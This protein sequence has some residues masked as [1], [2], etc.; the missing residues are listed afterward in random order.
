METAIEEAKSAIAKA[1]QE[2]ALYYNRRRTPAPV[3]RK[4]DRVF[5]DASDISTDRPSEKLGNLRY[6][7]LEVEEKVRPASYRLKLP[8]E[9]HCLHPVFPVVK[10]TP[11]PE[12]P[13][14]G[15]QQPTPPPPIIVDNVEEY[16]VEEILNSR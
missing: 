15:R 7:P 3:F 13:F 2:Y 12:E 9:M 14:P 11:V 1:Q 5:L 16:E 4:G 10:L 8:H 6:G